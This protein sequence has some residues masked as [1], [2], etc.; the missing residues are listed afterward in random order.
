MSLL[1]LFSAKVGGTPPP[2]PTP[3]G[4]LEFSGGWNTR[5]KKDDPWRLRSAEE[6]AEAVKQD[7]IRFGVIPAEVTEV[8]SRHVEQD[9]QDK[10]S[11]KERKLRL[12][13]ALAN[14]EIRYKKLYEAY[15]RA[16]YAK[17]IAEKQVFDDAPLEP[18]PVVEPVF[19]DDGH[20]ALSRKRKLM[21]ML[22]ILASD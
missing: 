5:K 21:K 12:K 13:T 1:L 16:V 2:P 19:V 7:R 9:A 3:P 17:Y 20:L 4:T 15:Y 6:V 22:V 11:E 14:E 18:K 8:V 10:Q